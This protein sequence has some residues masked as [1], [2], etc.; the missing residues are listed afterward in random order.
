MPTL[1]FETLSGSRAYGLA[2]PDSDR[3]LR[4]IVVGPRQWYFGIRPAP[5]QID[6]R[7]DDH[8]RT[9]LRKFVRLAAQANPTILEVLWSDPSD[10]QTMTRW[11]EALLAARGLFLTRRVR[12][13]FGAYAMSQLRRI[14]GHRS[15][16]LDPP[17]SQPR[18]SDF[19]LPDETVIPKE[20]LGA[21]EMLIESGDFDGA[22]ISP[23]F[24]DLLRREKAYKTARQ[25]YQQYRHWLEHRNPARA[26]LEARFGYDTKH[27]MHLVR[28]LRMAHEILVDREVHVRRPDREE[29]LAIKR[30]EWSYEALIER[31]DALSREI[32][33]CEPHS[34]LPEECD[35]E[36][37]EAL[38][39]RLIDDVL[40]S[41]ALGVSR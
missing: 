33:R 39:V 5:E 8:V 13:S 7:G 29:L 21:A 4:G 41:G 37:A 10:H 16:L 11:G 25:Q 26:E 17:R 32:E 35:V 18:R 1:I 3:D 31:C 20:Q 12:G 28:L 38:C 36:A 24:L 40:R 22:D 34:E 27:A 15:W 30:G 23:N 9:E 2:D 19:G 14:R 6:V